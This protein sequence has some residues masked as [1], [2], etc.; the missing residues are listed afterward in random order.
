LQRLIGGPSRG[1]APVTS[2]SCGGSGAG[3]GAVYD[4]RA[5]RVHG[6]DLAGPEW[7]RIGTPRSEGSCDMEAFF[8]WV[9]VGVALGIVLV[10]RRVPPRSA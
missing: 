7:G 3:T 6:R 1:F 4:A 2:I 5:T 9:L 8:V 10:T